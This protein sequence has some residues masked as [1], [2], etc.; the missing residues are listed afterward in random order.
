MKILFVEDERE[1]T[2]SALAYL[3]KEK[4]LCEIASDF[5]SAVEKINLYD[6]DIYII[7]L[8]LP[9]GKG[10]DL[11]KLIKTK[12]PNKGIIITSAQ[13]TLDDRIAGLNAGA[14]D[15]LV[16]PYFL[17]EL[18]ARIL[19]LMRRISFKGSNYVVFNEIR[20]DP[21]QHQ[22]F[23]K[24]ELLDLTRKEYDLLLFLITNKGRVLSKESIAEHLWGDYMDG[25]DSFDVVYTHIK[26][27]RKKL[28][29][30]GLEN[31]LQTV[32]GLG[33]KFAEN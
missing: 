10:S 14:D 33:Y 32:Y 2:D 24:E 9:D 27:L 12:D 3:Q 1:L 11:I 17:A 22:A 19:S 31:Y 5:A 13:N 7:D 23:I 29:D 20:I 28:T 18:N 25:A 21:Y 15:Y 26:N 4:Y 6:Y 8:N 30:K 16:K